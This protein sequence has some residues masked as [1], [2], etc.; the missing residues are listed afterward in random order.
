LN[1]LVTIKLL[2]SYV[3]YYYGLPDRGT[4]HQA[5]TMEDSRQQ[6]AYIAAFTVSSYATTTVRTTKPFNPL[7]GETY[8]AGDCHD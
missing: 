5:A 2:I 8:E 3:I 4:C 7:L 6:L 1:V